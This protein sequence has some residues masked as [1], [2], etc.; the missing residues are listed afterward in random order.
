MKAT[1]EE[2]QGRF[3]CMSAS[4]FADLLCLPPTTS[5]CGEVALVS[6]TWQV[7]GETLREP[8]SRIHVKTFISVDGRFPLV[9]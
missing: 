3:S 2:G 5:R 8:A 1:C 6:F 4:D 7:T 9:D